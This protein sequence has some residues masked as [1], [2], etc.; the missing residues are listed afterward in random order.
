MIALENPIY[1]VIF[2]SNKFA[3]KHPFEQKHQLEQ[4]L[5]RIIHK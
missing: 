1:S 2:K 3:W 5:S 4:M